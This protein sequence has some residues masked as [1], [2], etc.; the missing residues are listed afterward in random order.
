[1]NLNQLYIRSIEHNLNPNNNNELNL[2]E[3]IE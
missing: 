3:K 1:M 2:K